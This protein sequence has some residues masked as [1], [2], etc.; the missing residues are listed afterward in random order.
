MVGWKLF[1]GSFMNAVITAHVSSIAQYG[2]VAIS[3]NF[4]L[5]SGIAST[6]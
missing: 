2:H 1:S 4:T 6:H 5:G 3:N